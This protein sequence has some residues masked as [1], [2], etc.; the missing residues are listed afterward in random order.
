ME[1]TVLLLLWGTVVGLDLVTVPQVMIARPLV[2]GT[3]AGAILGDP[4]SGAVVGAVLELFALD[5]LPVG[6]VR[7]P[8][9]GLGAVAAAATVAGAPGSLGT[10]VGVAVGLVVAYLGQLG[11]GWTR[12]RNT[13]DVRRTRESLDRG[14]A[15]SVRMI[16]LRGLGRDALRA[17]A[18]S[19]VGLLLARLVYLGFPL[20]LRTAV[21]LTV[22]VVGAGVGTAA[23]GAMRLSG[24]GIRLGW[25][26][27]G[28]LGGLAWVVAA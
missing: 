9:Y 4:T 15:R 24:R 28:L 17:A 3:V 10:G 5:V 1:T 25:F 23:V 13:I 18:I 27:L 22:A 6:A 20:P 21:M 26:T 16:H 8:D 7:Y 12:R 2:A 11:M 14:D 19:T